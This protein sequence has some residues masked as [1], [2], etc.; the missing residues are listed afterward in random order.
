MGVGP[1]PPA[2]FRALLVAYDAWALG[3]RD[4]TRKWG[5][6]EDG[7]E[8]SGCLACGTRFENDEDVSVCHECEH[9]V[10]VRWRVA[11][12]AGEVDRIAEAIAEGAG[13]S[14]ALVS[15]LR[16]REAE[17]RDAAAQLEH[18]NELARRRLSSRRRGRTTRSCSGSS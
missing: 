1:P 16:E 7:D 9:C 6:L 10:H 13:D 18:L 11:K 12:L 14:K 8:Y 2:D 3:A 5:A 4:R 17:H 15:K